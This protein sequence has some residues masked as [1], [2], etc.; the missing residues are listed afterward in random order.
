MKYVFQFARILA[1]CVLGEA[2]HAL[3]PLPIP[4]SI[5][6]LVLFLLA[7]RLHI[8]TLD[9]VK[10]TARFLTGIFLVLF[11]PGT[12]G[13]VEHLDVLR[14]AWLPALIAL[15][16]VTAAVFFVSGKV[17]ESMLRRQKND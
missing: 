1:F 4:A 5:Y 2:L 10:E 7:L 11:I 3:L 16:P 17:T 12:V 8:V 6:G 14:A 13:I 15:I 9:Q